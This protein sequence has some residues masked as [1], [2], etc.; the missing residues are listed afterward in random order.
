MS[1]DKTLFPGITLSFALIFTTLFGYTQEAVF[2]YFA[3]LLVFWVFLDLV[4][5]DKR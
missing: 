4:D 1:K 5:Y 2:G 3:A